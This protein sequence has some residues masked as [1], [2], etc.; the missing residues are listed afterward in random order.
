[1]SNHNASWPASLSGYAKCTLD[2]LSEPYKKVSAILGEKN[3][4]E[5][6][7]MRGKFLCENCSTA[8]YWNRSKKF[9]SDVVV[10]IKLPHLL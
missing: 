3:R 1:M 5:T 10:F 7:F 2:S 4:E 9:Q 8:F 6:V